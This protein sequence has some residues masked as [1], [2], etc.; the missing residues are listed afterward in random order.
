M[1]TAILIRMP[2][3]ASST[4]QTSGQNPEQWADADQDGYGDNYLYDINQTNQLH[5]N[6]RGDAFPMDPQQWND[7][8]G[9]GY[10][11]NYD[12]PAWTANRARTGQVSVSRAP[13]C[14]MP[15]RS[16]ARSGPTPTVTASVTTPIP[17]VGRV[18]KR[19]RG[20]LLGPFG[21]PRQRR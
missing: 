8:D 20:L 14:P 13:R 5:I 12:D 6:Q 19:G 10:G 18:S 21:V 16:T 17:D 9:D 11:D 3:G 1:E 2:D 7:T 4:V 15:S